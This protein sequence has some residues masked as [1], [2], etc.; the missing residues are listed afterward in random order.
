MNRNELTKKL[1]DHEDNFTERKP[2]GANRSEL[3]ATMVAFANSIPEAREAVLFL[4]ITNDGEPIGVRNPDTL[5]KT[6]RQIAEQ[7][8]YPPVTYSIEVLEVSGKA[9]LAIVIGP[10]ENRPHFSGPAFV[11]KGSENVAATPELFEELIASRNAKTGAI[12]RGRGKLVTVIAHK[13]LG[14]TKRIGDSKYRARHECIVEDCDAHVVRLF[15][16][17]K[18]NYLAE[19]IDK[20]TVHYDVENKRMMLEVFE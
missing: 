6:I 18:E 20:V 12:L 3:R 13:I 5:Q 4:G 8:C 10:S 11:R 15:E 1:S 2:E 7:D 16:P 17:S 9:V 14:S 19:P